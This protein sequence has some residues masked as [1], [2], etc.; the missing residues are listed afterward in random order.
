[1]AVRSAFLEVRDKVAR[2]VHEMRNACPDRRLDGRRALVCAY[3]LP[4]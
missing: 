3:D 1:V 2:F 4:A